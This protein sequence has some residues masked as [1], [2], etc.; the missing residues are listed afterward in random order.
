LNFF[1]FKI[2]INDIIINYKKNKKIKI[3][4]IYLKIFMQ[5]ELNFS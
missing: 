2:F 5:F 4:N 1:N 3:E